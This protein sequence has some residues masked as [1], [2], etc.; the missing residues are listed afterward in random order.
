MGLALTLVRLLTDFYSN[1]APLAQLAPNLTRPSFAP[2][3]M[4]RRSES[5]QCTCNLLY[6]VVQ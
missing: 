1:L 2:M 6:L 5:L 3:K 4:K